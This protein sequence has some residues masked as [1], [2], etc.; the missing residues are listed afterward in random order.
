MYGTKE[1]IGEAEDYFPFVL[2]PLGI[3]DEKK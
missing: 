1:E 3:G 2:I